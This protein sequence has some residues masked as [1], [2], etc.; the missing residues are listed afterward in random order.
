[1]RPQRREFGPPQRRESGPPQRR[2]FGPQ[3]RR[4]FRPQERR[5]FGQTERR[6]FAPPQRPFHRPFDRA[7]GR[8]YGQDRPPVRPA[9]PP[10]TD[11]NDLVGPDDELVAGRHPVQEAF[12][13]R[14]DAVRL[15]V[16]PE[17]REA[18]DNLVIHA[19]TL[20]IPVVEVEGGTLTSLAGFDGHQGVALVARRRH[21]ATLD[22]VLTL[23]SQRGQAPFVLV[24][25]S[26]EDPQNFGTLLRSAEATGVHGVIYPAR[27][28]VPLTP[29]AIKA[30]AGATEHLLL[31]P[32]ADL[33]ATLADLRARGVRTVGADQDAPLTFAEADL[34]GPLA[35]VV[36]SEGF[37]ISGQLRR[38][39]DMSVKIP[40]RGKIASLNAAVAGSVLLFAAAEG[41]PDAAPPP[42]PPAAAEPDAPRAEPDAPRAEPDA[43]RA[44]PDAPPAQP[45]A[46]PAEPDTRP[47]VEQDLLPGDT[48]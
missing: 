7:E 4:D 12:A 16:V 11:T 31:A 9:P 32:V 38:R 24:L 45:D 19:T 33:A 18:L 6:E 34:R 14:R 13:A 46:P 47:A 37:G 36:G 2:E 20:R 5:E 40:M 3:Q 8:P 22:D 25:D 29:A 43:P 28:A 21:D 39:L 30:A 27:R 1:M 17:R 44:E 10:R 42:S 41:R 35:L 26:L 48:E 23:A 15:L